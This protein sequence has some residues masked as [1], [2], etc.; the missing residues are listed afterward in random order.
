MKVNCAENTHKRNKCYNNM[1]MTKFV[2]RNENK[3]F[4]FCQF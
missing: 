1:K 2:A 3:F 4:G